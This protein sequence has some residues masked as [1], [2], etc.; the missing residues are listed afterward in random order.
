ML[1]VALLLMLFGCRVPPTT[2][3]IPPKTSV[4]K[5]YVIHQTDG[6]MLYVLPDGSTVLMDPLEPLR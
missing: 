6:T 3:Y 5:L 4:H 2:R 1:R